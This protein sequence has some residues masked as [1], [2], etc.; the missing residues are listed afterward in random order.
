MKIFTSTETEG[1]VLNL[2]FTV[3]QIIIQVETLISKSQK[4]GSKGEL[5]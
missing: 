5:E 1:T 4:M 3:N 2:T